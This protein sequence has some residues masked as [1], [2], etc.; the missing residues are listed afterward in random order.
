MAAGQKDIKKKQI[1]L[2]MNI[3]H[4]KQGLILIHES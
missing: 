2:M 3:F 4:V 1:L